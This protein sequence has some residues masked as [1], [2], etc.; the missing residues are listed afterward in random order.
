MC[1]IYFCPS[2]QKEKEN[3]QIRLFGWASENQVRIYLCNREIG[4]LSMCKKGELCG[5]ILRKGTKKICKLYKF[6]SPHLLLPDIKKVQFFVLYLLLLLLYSFKKF[7]LNFV[8]AFFLYIDL[9][10]LFLQYM[11]CCKIKGKSQ[12]NTIIGFLFVARFC[13]HAFNHRLDIVLKGF[14]GQK[15]F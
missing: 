5:E 4:S 1:L 12:I 10:V 9:C 15:P 11:C 13:T 2:W 3:T 8:Y 14:K 7:K 6:N